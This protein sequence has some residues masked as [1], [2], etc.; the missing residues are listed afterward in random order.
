MP[1]A[2]VIVTAIESGFGFLL[3]STMLYLVVSR[4]K[5]AYHYLFAAFL[6][7]CALWDLA[8]FLLMIRNDHLGEVERLGYLIMPCLLLPGLVLHFA[9]LYTGRRMPRLISAVWAVTGVSLLLGLAGLYW[10]IDGVYKYDWGNI[11][12]VAPSVVDLPAM[13]GL[14]GVNLYACWL[15]FDASRRAATPLERRHYLYVFSGILVLTLAMVK[16]GVVMGIDVPILLPLGMFFV[17]VF[18]AIMGAAIIK[19]RLFD[20]TVIIKKGTVYSA[21]AALLIFV[22][23]LSEHVF[24][25]YIAE[26]FREYSNLAHFVSIAVGIA[27]LFPVKSRLERATEH[28]FANRRLEF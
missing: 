17:D 6:L 27:V 15:L 22:Y 2:I 3:T 28:Y 20:I 11:F 26:T 10:R 1:S 5:K 13:V 9:C 18:N 19:H 16:V 8:T 4:G 24:I 7:V 12:R 23:S 25:T 14:F 21:L